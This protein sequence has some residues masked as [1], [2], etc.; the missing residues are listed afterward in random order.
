MAHHP[1]DPMNAS[2]QRLLEAR[3]F[4]KVQLMDNDTTTLWSMRATT[5]ST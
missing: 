4:N 5:S 1:D 2:G 3:S